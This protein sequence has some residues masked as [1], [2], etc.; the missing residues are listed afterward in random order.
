MSRRV[1]V[2]SAAAA[3]VAVAAVVTAVLVTSSDA[4]PAQQVQVSIRGNLGGSVIV[5]GDQTIQLKAET[6][7]DQVTVTATE[8]VH[9]SATSSGGEPRCSVHTMAGVVLVE[10]AGPAPTVGPQTMV[11]GGG[12]ADV[13]NAPSWESVT[14]EVDLTK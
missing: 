5:D 4:R 8:T 9:V 14:C 7:A 10:K 11:T 3:I 1:I 2:L 12:P 6:G 13:V